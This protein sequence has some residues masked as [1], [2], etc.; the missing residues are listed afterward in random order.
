MGLKGQRT[1]TEDLS[2]VSAETREETKAAS[3]ELREERQQQEAEPGGVMVAT[4][5]L[6]P[7]V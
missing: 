4:V 6:S 3:E 5:T 7:L 2:E 1:F